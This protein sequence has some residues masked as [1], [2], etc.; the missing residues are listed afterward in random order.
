MR[1]N[2][3]LW[4]PLGLIGFALV[5]LGYAWSLPSEGMI[6]DRFGYD[7]GSRF[8]PVAAG[9]VLAAALL[10]DLLRRWPLMPAPV[11][12]GPVLAHVVALIVYLIAFR[13]LGFV[14][15]TAFVLFGLIALNQR[16]MGQP[17]RLW[18]FVCAMAAV[19]VGSVAMFTAVRWVIRSCFALARTHDLPILREPA[20]QA[21]LATVAVVMAMGMMIWVC[22]RWRHL[23]YVAAVQVAIGTTFAIYLLFRQLF[24][25]QLPPGILNW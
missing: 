10:G 4:V 3:A 20:V 5:W 1:H 7:P 16:H 14:L 25:I 8:L 17:F 24:L 23:Q 12:T 15:S 6:G 19:A 13:P 11:Q 9:I 22:R 2:L 21:G 18:P